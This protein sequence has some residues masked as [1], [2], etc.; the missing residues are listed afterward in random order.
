MKKISVILF[1]LLV[2]LMIGQVTAQ[3]KERYVFLTYVSGVEYWLEWRR[4]MK[5]AGEFFQVDV[6]YRGPIEYDPPA[7]ARILD[8]L[9]ATKPAGIVIAVA[10]PGALRDAINRAI[11]AGIPV[12]TCDSDSPDS[13]RIAYAGTNNYRAGNNGGTFFAEYLVQ[14]YGTAETI[15][16]GFSGMIGNTFSEDRVRGYR[17]AFK[18]YPNIKEVG[19]VNDKSDVA[20]AINVQTALINAHP[21]LKAFVGVD[22]IAGPSIARAVRETGREGKISIMAMDR[23]RDTLEEIRRGNIV[24]TVVQKTHLE[25][26]ISLA[27]LYYLN[28]DAIDMWPGWR[29]VGL[30]MSP[31]PAEIDTGTIVVTKENVDL[32]LQVSK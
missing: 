22:G 6:D 21:K 18:K 17:D 27:L 3:A 26:F 9:I 31:I 19:Y 12:I 15:E 16:V 1:G 32:L 25:A 4:G 10:D 28:H 5:E 11:D 29:K 20:V 30:S 8:E 13:K 24:G 23:N 7:Q 2:L 14:K